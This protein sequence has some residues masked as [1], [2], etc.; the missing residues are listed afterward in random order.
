MR[1]RLVLAAA[2]LATLLVGA[3]A[4]RIQAQNSE[5]ARAQTSLKSKIRSENLLL[6]EIE[7]AV[8]NE[9]EDE[10]LDDEMDDDDDEDEDDDDND[11]VLIEEEDELWE[12]ELMEE[13][14][15]ALLEEWDED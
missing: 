12:D 3:S 9:E 11:L 8:D 5:L 7:A 6:A 4:Y 13:D 2:I 10:L 15:E 14:V 1:I